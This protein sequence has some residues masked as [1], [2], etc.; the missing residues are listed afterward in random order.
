MRQVSGALGIAVFGTILQI[1]YGRQ[2]TDALTVLPG[3]GPGGRDAVRITFAPDAAN[4]A[5]I[6][7][8]IPRDAPV[9]SATLPSSEISMRRA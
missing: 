9:T 8:P 1:V 4:E 6:A 3:G 7:L 5:A 2:I